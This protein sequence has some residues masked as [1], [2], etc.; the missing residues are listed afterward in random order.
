MLYLSLLLVCFSILECRAQ[1]PVKLTFEQMKAAIIKKNIFVP[2]KYVRPAAPA[3][4]SDSTTVSPILDTGPKELEKPFVVIGITYQ[5]DEKWADLTF[6]KEQG[7]RKV[8]KGDVIETITIKDIFSTYLL[9]DYAGQEVR[10]GQGE[11]SSDA[12]RRVKGIMGGE[13]SLIGTSDSAAHI[14][15]K[16]ESRPRWFYVGNILGNAKVVEIQPGKVILIDQ[17]GDKRIL[18]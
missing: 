7:R 2:A 16:G 14:L 15:I 11:S 5:Q 6:L 18:E 3:E 12:Y 9:C 4:A 13:Y 10:I 17:Y 1:E 8:K